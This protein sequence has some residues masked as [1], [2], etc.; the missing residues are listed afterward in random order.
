MLNGGGAAS[1]TVVVPAAAAATP[2]S[3]VGAHVKADIQPL[4]QTLA[5]EKLGERLASVSE[6]NSHRPCFCVI[7]KQ[8]YSARVR[9]LCC[10]AAAAAAPSLKQVGQCRRQGAACT[11]SGR[12]GR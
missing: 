8:A 12:R 11:D 7:R 6:L 3:K 10:R 1:A 5:D 4:C 9:Q 2:S